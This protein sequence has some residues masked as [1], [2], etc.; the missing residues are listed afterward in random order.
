MAWGAV[1]SAQAQC[2]KRLLAYYPYYNGGYKSGKIPF[3]ELTHIAHAF[4]DINPDGTISIPAGYLEPALLTSAHAA[5]VKVLVSVGGA[6]V[7]TFSGVAANA[8]YTT[9]FVNAIYNFITTYNYDGVDIDWEFPF[10]AADKTNG[11]TFFQAI[12]TKFD[13]SPAPAPT[14]EISMAATGLSYYGAYINFASLNGILSFYN[15]MT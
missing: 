3:S 5:G 2:A 15:I 14:W 11:V 6:D 8:A 9:T 13:S 4:I 1:V 7:I 12:R 10:S